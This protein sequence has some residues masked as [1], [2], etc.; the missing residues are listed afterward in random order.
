MK[1]SIIP[2]NPLLKELAK[3]LRSNMTYSEVVLWNELKNGKMLAYDF[4]RQRPILEYIVDFYC[5]DLMLAL[6]IDGLS[7]DAEIEVVKDKERQIQ[8]ESAGVHFLRFNA[9][10]VVRDITNIR[11]A[12]EGWIFDYEDKNGIPEHISNKRDQLKTKNI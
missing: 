7:H 5:K 8:L 12:I 9:L 4:D 1:R 11:R 3:K 10:Q 2:Y 6:E